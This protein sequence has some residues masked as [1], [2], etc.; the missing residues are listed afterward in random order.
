VCSSDLVRAAIAATEER[1]RTLETERK[2]LDNEAEFYLGKPMPA[3]L[4]SA[5]DAN[6]AA[7]GAQREIA[8]AQQAEVERVNRIYDTELTRLRRLWTGAPPGSMGPLEA[9]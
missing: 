4:R 2:P 6:D 8:A 3:K 7:M 5:L 9:P 1:M